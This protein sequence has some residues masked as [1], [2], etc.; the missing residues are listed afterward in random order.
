MAWEELQAE[1]LLSFRSICLTAFG[2]QKQVVVSADKVPAQRPRAA[3]FHGQMSAAASQH[4]LF[5]DLLAFA[6][7]RS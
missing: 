7:V 6:A 5:T 3:A 2:W 1:G 4:L